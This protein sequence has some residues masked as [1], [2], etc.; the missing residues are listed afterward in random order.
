M[1]DIFSP[2]ANNITQ[3]KW[4]SILY[5]ATFIP[6]WVALIFAVRALIKRDISRFTGWSL[7]L[8]ILLALPY[9]YVLSQ[10]SLGIW[11]VW[12]ATSLLLLLSYFRLFF[13][14][15]TLSVDWFWDWYAEKYDVLE[16]FSPYTSLLSQLTEQTNSHTEAQI[17]VLEIGCGTGNIAKSLSARKN[18][19]YLGIDSSKKM[20]QKAKKKLSKNSNFNFLTQDAEAAL[21][22]IEQQFDIV[23]I[24]N[25]LYAIEFHEKII[26]EIPRLL[27]QNSKVIISE[28]ERG[29]SISHLLRGHFKKDKI[30]ALLNVL[31]HLPSFVF[32][33][34][35]NIMILE[36]EHIKKKNF[37]SK[38]ELTT[39]LETNGFKIEH[40]G[41]SYEN[42]NILLVATQKNK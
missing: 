36:I 7:I 40:L 32:V 22:N 27:S 3:I 39:I 29:S 38:S 23:I 13:G 9:A 41:S 37:F 17:R 10:T 26:S 35:A 8:I 15:K 5:I 19:S 30:K 14:G 42:Q 16:Y 24:N 31:G 12:V 28:P 21:P 20:I 33:L 34:V 4:F 1:F 25:V 6:C 11:Q 18:I 2:V